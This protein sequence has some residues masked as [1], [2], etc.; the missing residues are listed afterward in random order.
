MQRI[1]SAQ[2]RTGERHCVQ[3]NRVILDL[4]TIVEKKEGFMLLT[5]RVSQKKDALSS[6]ILE[7]FRD[8]KQNKTIEN[9]NFKHLCNRAFFIGNPV[10][11]IFKLTEVF[12]VV[13]VI[14]GVM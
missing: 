4:C 14:V 11:F 7:L 10:F 8:D 12:V 13:V 1:S 2:Q 9:I 5:Y 6:N 3:V